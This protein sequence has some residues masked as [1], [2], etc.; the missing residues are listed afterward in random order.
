MLG[1]ILLSSAT[2]N[3][4]TIEFK[5]K[6]FSPARVRD[7]D[8]HQRLV[9]GT[10]HTV[11]TYRIHLGDNIYSVERKGFG[12]GCL[13]STTPGDRIYVLVDGKKM[14]VLVNGK[15]SRYNIVGIWM[16]EMAQ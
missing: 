6:T 15:E 7:F 5:G 2:V 11:R 12:E 4:Q 16:D 14:F 13:S 10:S 9:D 3:S 8:S 1:T